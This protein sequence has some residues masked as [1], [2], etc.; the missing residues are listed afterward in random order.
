[1]EKTTFAH[2]MLNEDAMTPTEHLEAILKASAGLQNT[3]RR[4][5]GQKVLSKS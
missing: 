3:P 5:H 2:N 4:C 1:M